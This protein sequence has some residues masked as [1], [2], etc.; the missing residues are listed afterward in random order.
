MKLQCV[1]LYVICILVSI[2]VIV[3]VILVRELSEIIASMLNQSNIELV[4]VATEEEFISLI[5]DGDESGF[6][7]NGVGK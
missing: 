4:G 7:G 2:I 1:A 5:A 6:C 3:I